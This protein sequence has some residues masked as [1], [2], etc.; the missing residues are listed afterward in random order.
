[1]AAAGAVLTLFD[2]RRV[3]VAGALLTAWAA[4]RMRA[5][6]RTGQLAES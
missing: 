2:T 5:W 4:F 6:S 3:L 1:M